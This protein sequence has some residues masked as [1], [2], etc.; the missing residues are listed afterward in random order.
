[1]NAKAIAALQKWKLPPRTRFPDGSVVL[2]EI[3]TN[4]GT[5]TTCSVM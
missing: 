5:P 4:G 1:M 2:R 3:L